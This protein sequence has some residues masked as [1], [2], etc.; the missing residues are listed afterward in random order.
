MAT[1]NSPKWYRVSVTD[2]VEI[3]KDKLIPLNNRNIL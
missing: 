1:T 3:N 2:L